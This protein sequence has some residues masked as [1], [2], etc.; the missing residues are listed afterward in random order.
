ML[1][2]KQQHNSKGWGQQQMS[3]WR[4]W[5]QTPRAALSWLWL[6]LVVPEQIHLDKI[7]Q[8][9]VRFKLGSHATLALIHWNVELFSKCKLGD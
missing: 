7:L 6:T 3:T 1:M 4:S 9:K 8:E 2:T 5:K